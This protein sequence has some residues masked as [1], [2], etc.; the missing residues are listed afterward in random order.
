MI[1]FYKRKVGD[2][3]I[4]KLNSFKVGCWINVIDPSEKELKELCKK[5]NL[6]ERNV[7]SGLDQNEIPR[8]DFIEDNIYVLTKT[9]L[10]PLKLQTFL[11]VISKTFV[12]TLSKHSHEPL[13]EVLSN[14]NEIYTTQKLKFLI[15]FLSKITD[16]FETE[17][18]K[19]VK[20]IQSKKRDISNR[21]L[22]SLLE[23]EEFLNKLV[24]SYTYLNLL[25]NRMIK[26][27]SFYKQD[28]EILEDLIEE[29][30]EGTNL[31]K[32][33]LKTISN[34]RDHYVVLLSN[35]LN[36][37]INVLTIFTILISLPAA[38]SGIYGMNVSLPL[39]Q[40]PNVFWY[41]LGFI[42]VIWGL[43]LIYLRKLR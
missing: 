14:K 25:Y 31:S 37:L 38:V 33:S 18:R 1:T 26:K 42:G 20:E 7:F 21:T 3:K 16:Y 27:I 4:R 13:E 34:I 23:Q 30:N 41:I 8:L 32:S 43:F 35:K 19:T 10:P 2:K 6:D 22:E 5:Y 17:T 39:Q 15:K 9:V 40:D 24:S 12:L 11:I 28:K 29:I 36:K